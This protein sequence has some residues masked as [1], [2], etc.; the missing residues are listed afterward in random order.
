MEN[1]INQILTYLQ[2]QRGFDFT[3]NRLLMIQRRISKRFSL[4]HTKN[5]KEYFKYILKNNAELDK[6]INVLTINVSSFFRDI[7]VFKHLDLI[8]N[9]LVLKKQNT[10]DNSI[11]I[12]SA[13]CAT[14]EEPYSI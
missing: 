9:E 11:R 12:W 8:L 5:L 3:G 2:E 7:L 13:G 1:T 10:K 14:G 6:L 4:T